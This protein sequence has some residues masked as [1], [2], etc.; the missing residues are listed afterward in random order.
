[1]GSYKNR[2]IEFEENNSEI[3][4]DFIDENKEEFIQFCKDEN[5]IIVEF[6]E[7]KE[8]AWGRFVIER[9]NDE[10][11]DKADYDYDMS[12][13]Q[14]IEAEIECIKEAKHEI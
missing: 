6:K 10:I 9:F 11:V 14:I 1:M 5:D 13:D 2:L 7:L 12:R 3:E 8:E 4:E